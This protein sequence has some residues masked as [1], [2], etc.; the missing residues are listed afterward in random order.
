MDGPSLRATPEEGEPWDDP[1]EERLFLLLQDIEAGHGDFVI[2]ARTDDPNAETYAQAL[3]YDDG[4]YTVEHREGDKEHH[5]ATVAPDMRTAW[6][7]PH[8]LGV[9]APWL[10]RP[11]LLVKA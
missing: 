11:G 7:D 5:Y 4:T 2:V 6:P 8:R 1:T 10:G 3:R 9:S